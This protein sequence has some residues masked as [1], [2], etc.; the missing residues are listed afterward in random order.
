M[1]EQAITKLSNTAARVGWLNRL[2]ADQA[3]CWGR[4]ERVLVEAYVAREPSLAGDTEALLDLLYSEVM[5]REEYGERASVE[6]YVRRFPRHEAALRR[7]FAVHEALRAPSANGDSQLTHTQSPKPHKVTTG[8]RVRV[9]DQQPLVGSEQQSSSDALSVPATLPPSSRVGAHAFAQDK[10]PYSAEVPDTARDV[11]QPAAAENWPSLPAYEIHGVLGRG[12]MGVVYKARQCGLNRLVAIKMVLA[13]EHARPEDLVRFLA[14]AEA[15][16][17]LRHPHIVQIYEIS[18]HAGLPFFVMEY[19]DGGSLA[20]RLRQAPLPPREAALTAEKIAHGVQA[21]H[22]RGIIHRDLKPANIL[23]AG[24]VERS[25]TAE[26]AGDHSPLTTHQP[27]ITD[28]G[29]AKRV[30]GGGGLTQTGD[31]MGTPS[32]MAPEQAVGKSGAVG[33]A[34]DVYGLGATLYEMLTGRPPFRAATTFDTILQVIANEPVPPTRLQPQVPRDL[35]TICLKCLHKDANRRYAT[36][37][38]L[39]ADLHHFLAGEP[40][41]ARP[42]GQGERLWRW[43]RRHPGVAWLSAALLLALLAGFVAVTLLWRDAEAQ[44]AAASAMAAEARH[45]QMIAE[46]E[47]QRAQTEANKAN[48]TV[49]FLAQLFEATDPL[50]LGGVPALRPRSADVPTVLQILERGAERANRELSSEPETQAKLLDTIGSVYCTL[51]QTDRAKPLLEKALVLRRQLHDDRDIA[52]TLHNLG[53]LYH[54]RGDYEAARRYYQEALAIRQRDVATDP[55]P[56]SATMLNLGWLHADLEDFAAAEE[57]FKNVI[58]LRVSQLGPQ[59]RDTAVA[60]GALAAMYLAQEK[61]A[62]ALVPYQQAMAILR[63]TEGTQSLA[64]AIDLFN[65]GV[66]A[67][68]ANPLVRLSLGMKY[69]ESGADCL[70]KSLALAK[71]HLSAKHAFVALILHELGLTLMQD[72]KNEEAERYFLECLDIARAYGLDHPKTTYLLANFGTLLVRLGQPVR[73]EQLLAEAMQARRKRYSGHHYLVKEVQVLQAGLVE[74]LSHSERRQLLREALTQGSP[75]SGGL[76]R[77]TEFSVR[78]M[79]ER[80]SPTELCDIAS[81]LAAAAAQRKEESNERK[82]WEDLALTT[83]RR[84]RQKGFHDV[85]RLSHDKDLDNL[86]G[87]KDFQQFVAELRGSSGR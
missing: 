24:R 57:L 68:S 35:E 50:G 51:G 26:G 75:S 71:Q 30:Q 82:E 14:E 29:L 16:A 32:Y 9:V 11:E 37:A 81:D 6:E 42:V 62:A 33:P 27:K 60:Y 21:A 54:Q 8:D 13:G 34:T 58:D 17:Q 55:K 63:K 70:R 85:E 46:N 38:A 67:R 87:R 15:V 28:F 86:R 53:W 48:K 45:Q 36:P 72:K 2:R 49:E 7:Q 18:R 3:E 22:E 78:R 44:R 66:I 80:L 59:D 12:A 31:V 1:S 43:C 23:L 61:A 83:L 56:L 77:W 47:S 4:G 25:A 39:A 10:D 40:I 41:E 74:S 65:R 52:A 20:Q 73:A 64:E 84:A 19:V 79:A 5:L 69:N 76:T